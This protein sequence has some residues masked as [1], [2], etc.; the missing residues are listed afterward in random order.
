MW[1]SVLVFHA[2]VYCKA[3]MC[4]FCDVQ[5]FGWHERD[6]LYPYLI[7]FHFHCCQWLIT[8]RLIV[9]FSIDDE[10]EELKTDTPSAGYPSPAKFTAQSMSCII[11]CKYHTHH[12]YAVFI[13]LQICEIGR[14][15]V[16][17]PVTWNDLVC[18]LLLEK[19][20]KQKAHITIDEK[21]HTNNHRVQLCM[22][23]N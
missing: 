15:H 13:K 10:E 3:C 12:S 4:V 9:Y 23:S 7:L 22:L 19:K 21:Q 8:Q 17:T 20:K 6:I 18:R 1:I 11:P 5:I 14:A 16:W 2:V